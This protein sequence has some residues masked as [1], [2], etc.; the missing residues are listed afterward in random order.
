MLKLE[1]IGISGKVLKKSEKINECKL[2]RFCTCCDTI[3][4]DDP[5]HICAV[6]AYAKSIKLE[7][8]VKEI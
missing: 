3:F 7:L 2:D 4:T 6:E 8:K 1:R 5:L